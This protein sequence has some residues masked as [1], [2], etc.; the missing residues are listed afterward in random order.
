MNYVEKFLEFV[1]FLLQENSLFSQFTQEIKN[2]E[3]CHA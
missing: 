3:K 2:Q 1:E